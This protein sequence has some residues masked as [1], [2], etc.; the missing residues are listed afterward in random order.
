MLRITKQADYGIVLMTHFGSAPE[1]E[2]MNAK[3]LA[4]KTALPLPMVSKILKRLTRFG[5]LISTRGAMGGYVLARSSHD[6]RLLEMI[7]A[8]EGPIAMTE[9][10]EADAQACPIESSCRTRVNWKLINQV[11]HQALEGV[12][13]AQMITPAP[14]CATLDQTIDM[15]VL[16]TAPKLES[17]EIVD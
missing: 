10:S 4:S 3:D 9:C 14:A 15:S 8:L 1:R 2:L 17:G 11:V 6:I 7:A 13:L 5:L 12:T 16:Q